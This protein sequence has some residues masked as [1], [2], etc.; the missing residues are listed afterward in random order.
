MLKFFNKYI[1]YNC[2]NNLPDPKTDVVFWNE[3]KNYISYEILDKIYN[4]IKN[5]KIHYYWD[6]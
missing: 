5:R 1:K 6:Y 3:N 4:H 2:E